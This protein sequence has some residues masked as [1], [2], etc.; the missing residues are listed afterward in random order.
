MFIF[1]QVYAGVFPIDNNDFQKL[2]ESINRVNDF[3]LD[4]QSTNSHEIP[5]V[6]NTDRPQRDRAAGVLDC[7]W[8]RLSAWFP[9]HTPYGCLPSTT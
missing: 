3:R 8:T 9:R 5:C 4:P 6:V 7:S 1:F 2:E